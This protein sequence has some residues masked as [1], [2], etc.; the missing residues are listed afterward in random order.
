MINS[1]L[2]A[3]TFIIENKD[4]FE[5]L[6]DKGFLVKDENG[7]YTNEHVRDAW[8]LYKKACEVKDVKIMELEDRLA[9]ANS[10]MNHYHK[11]NIELIAKLPDSDRVKELLLVNQ[12]FISMKT[13]LKKERRP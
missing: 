12:C 3:V 6:Y 11:E 13:M 4:N 7:Y 1:S 2:K 10:K 8:E 5:K 9:N